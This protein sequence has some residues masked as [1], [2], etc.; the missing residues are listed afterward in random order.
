MNL[1]L[2]GV[3]FSCFYW[4][5]ESVRDV[6]VFEKGTLLKRLF[7][8]DPMSFWTRLLVVCIIILYSVY[9]SSLKE[10][11]KN[12]PKKKR[13]EVPHN[14]KIIQGG[15]GFGVLYWIIEAFRDTVIFHQGNVIEEI[16]SPN[17]IRFWMRILPVAIL[18]LFSIYTIDVINRYKHETE[19]AKSS[20]KEKEVLLREIHHRVKNNLQVISS[21]LSLQSQYVTDKDALRMFK[22]TQN[23]V[24]SMALAHEK[25]Y[26]SENLAE[27]N[28]SDYIERLA[29][30]LYRSYGI[31]PK[32]IE[33]N[34]DVKNISMDIDRAI[35][36]GLVINE[37]ISNAL[38]HAFP[39]QW[40]KKKKI[41]ISLHKKETGELVLIVKDNGIGIPKEL[42]FRKT[43]SLGLR[44]VTALAE[45][46]LGGRIKLNREEGT[47]FSISLKGEVSR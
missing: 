26:Q 15:I 40:R 2:A 46:Q 41:K 18:V 19:K 6:V 7:S 16:F 29:D 13:T 11:T 23:R 4:I 25:L 8:P 31:N 42:D 27:I 14:K 28:C 5:L 32:D 22:E 35:P 10:K 12:N 36:C 21:L 43:E 20:L 17:S 38:K 45:E 9:V 37:L 3:L 34:I 1:I 44:L 24:R 39:P 47:E 30:G 33:L